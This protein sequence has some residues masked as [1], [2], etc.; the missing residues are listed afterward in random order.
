MAPPSAVRSRF[1]APQGQALRRPAS[2]PRWTSRC[3]RRRAAGAPSSP[4]VPRRRRRAA[5]AR[6]LGRRTSGP[7]R[8][9]AP[10]RAPSSAVPRPGPERARPE[11]RRHA[12]P[13]SG[14]PTPPS[15]LHMC[16]R[17]PPPHACRPGAL[18]GRASLQ[19]AAPATVP[20]CAVGRSCSPPGPSPQASRPTPTAVQ[21]G[22]LGSPSRPP[23]LSMG[24]PA[25]PRPP[26]RRSSALRAPAVGW[27]WTSWPRL[28][29]GP[30]R[31]ASRRSACR[32]C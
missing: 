27:P 22:P 4:T 29:G 24:P 1:H 18:Q 7:R 2:W 20:G 5:R 31:P 30:A 28:R 3:P 12:G 25:A 14:S 13:R 16:D 6:R 10:R 17:R 9:R 23:G 11:R 19:R 8:P 15:C 26:S 21:G 32:P